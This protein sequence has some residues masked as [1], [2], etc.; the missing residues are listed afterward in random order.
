[1]LEQRVGRLEEKVDRIEAAVVRID[2]MVKQIL[3]TCA[4]Q[5]ADII[6]IKATGAKQSDSHKLQ[7]EVA[8]IRSGGAKQADLNRAQVEL[9][10]V[11]GRVS[12]LPTWWMLV[13]AIL[14]TWGAGFAIAN[15]MNKAPAQIEKTSERASPK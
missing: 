13:T 12:T 10:E 1:M 15:S 8:E 14:A 2:G 11:K 9:A 3:E 7:L 5:S 6:E 4:K